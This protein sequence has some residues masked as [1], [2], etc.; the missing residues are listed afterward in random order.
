[1]SN[2]NP[3]TI[4]QVARS[5]KAKKTKPNEAKIQTIFISKLTTLYVTI[6]LVSS[7]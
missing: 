4:C 6:K 3:D 5:V 7:L 2:Q 1:M